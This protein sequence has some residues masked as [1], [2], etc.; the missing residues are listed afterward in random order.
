MFTT[1]TGKIKN[2]EHLKKYKITKGRYYSKN[3]KKYLSSYNFYEEKENT[4]EIIN[5]SVIKYFLKSLLNIHPFILNEY[6]FIRAY[7]SKTKKIDIFDTSVEIYGIYNKKGKVKKEYIYKHLTFENK[8]EE[9]ND[10]SI[11]F[12]ELLR[13]E[14][15]GIINKKIVI[16]F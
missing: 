10:V 5:N 16:K 9:L 4:K 1:K 12:L 11:S 6:F 7:H 2:M 3:N 8:T 15:P 14:N 13:I